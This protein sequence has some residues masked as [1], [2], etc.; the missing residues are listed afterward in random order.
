LSNGCVSLLVGTV[1]FS[2]TGGLGSTGLI[3]GSSGTRNFLSSSSESLP[4]AS[5]SALVKAASNSASESVCPFSLKADLISSLVKKPSVSLSAEVKNSST[6]YCVALLGRIFTGSYGAGS[7]SFLTGST[8][9]GS[10]GVVVLSI[11]VV[12]LVTG[13]TGSVGGV[14]GSVGGDSGTAGTKNFFSSSRESLPSASVSALTNAASSSASVIVCPFAAKAVFISSLVKKPS[15][16]V[17]A[18]FKKSLT[19]YSVALLGS[20]FA[21]VAGSTG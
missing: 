21:G 2:G 7:V 14:T 13:V 19:S 16:S 9:V 11:G 17:S 4:S 10:V 8:G 5:M 1:V 15:E 20:T 18:D 12:S 6:S 3:S